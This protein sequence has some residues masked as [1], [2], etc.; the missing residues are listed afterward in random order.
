VCLLGDKRRLGDTA[1]CCHQSLVEKKS[2]QH[3]KMTFEEPDS[4][5]VCAVL[6]TPMVNVMPMTMEVGK[7]AQTDLGSC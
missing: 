7:A 3:K 2:K 4:R 6:P 5:S 1:G